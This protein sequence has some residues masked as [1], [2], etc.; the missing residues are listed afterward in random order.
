[1][2]DYPFKDEELDPNI[3]MDTQIVPLGVEFTLWPRPYV[4][5]YT[6]GAIPGEL[7]IFNKYKHLFDM[8]PERT[9][10][11][12]KY[13]LSSQEGIK[14]NDAIICY[15]LDSP[16]FITNNDGTSNV[17]IGEYWFRCIENDIVVNQY[18]M[19]LNDQNDNFLF[20]LF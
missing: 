19:K 7:F 13:H 4:R 16:I 15:R 18:L 20:S 5:Q 8:K 14:Y 12:L 17:G 9:P 11:M 10:F 3:L 2:E 6:E 1:M